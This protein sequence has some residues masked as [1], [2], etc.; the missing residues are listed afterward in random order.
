MCLSKTMKLAEYNKIVE[1][2]ETVHCDGTKESLA[3]V[4]QQFP[5]VSHHTLISIY[6]QRVQVKTKGHHSQHTSPGAVEH[7]Y[8]KY[9]KRVSDPLYKW[10]TILVGLA[11][12][13]DFSPA[14][15]A[16]IVLERHL[17]YTSGDEAPVPKSRVTKLF[18]EPHLIQDPVLSLEVQQCVLLD[19]SYGPVVESIKHSIGVEL[20]VHLKKT[21][22]DHG[23]AFIG[24]EEMRKKGYDKT[25]DVKLQVPIAVGGR[26]VNWMESKASFGDRHS[27]ENYMRDQFWSYVNRFGSGLVIYWFG[28]IEELAT[29]SEQGIIV[30]D[31]FPKHFTNLIPELECAK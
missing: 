11:S 1:C 2:L 25:P 28:F 20:E 9:R 4:Q 6:S 27:H 7:Y 14:L 16:R 10:G 22:Q 23:L 31:D 18:R 3:L 29:S 17:F 21:L 19:S 30:A 5:S 15:L 13:I 12:E 26:V 24:E 8:A